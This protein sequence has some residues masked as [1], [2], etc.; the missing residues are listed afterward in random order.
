[1][2]VEPVKVHRPVGEELRV[3][4]AAD[5]DDSVRGSASLHW[6][7]LAGAPTHAIW[8]LADNDG[9]RLEGGSGQSAAPDKGY[10][11]DVRQEEAHR[12]SQARGYVTART[13]AEDEDAPSLEQWKEVAHRGFQR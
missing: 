5:A 4:F 3:R 13:A 6:R 7:L 11:V 9:F 10:V 12:G 2:D 8:S 1:L